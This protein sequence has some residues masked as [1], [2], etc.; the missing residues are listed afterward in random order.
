VVQEAIRDSLTTAMAF[1][2]VPAM[3][4][5]TV[6]SLAILL[7]VVAH[8]VAGSGAFVLC[9]GIGD[10]FTLEPTHNTSEQPGDPHRPCSDTNYDDVVIVNRRSNTAAIDATIAPLVLMVGDP[11]P[12][13]MNMRPDRRFIETPSAHD[14]LAHLQTVV[15]L[16]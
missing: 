15:M 1:P 16:I 10:H 7:C 2:I 13:I 14:G 9:D 12:Q 8:V 6:Q 3:Q 5:S 11:L 4:R